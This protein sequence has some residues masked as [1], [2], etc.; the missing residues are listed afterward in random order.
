MLV[1]RISRRS[2]SLAP[3]NA[4]FPQVLRTWLAAQDPAGPRLH[5]EAVSAEMLKA[6][7]EGGPPRRAALTVLAA[8]PQVNRGT[9]RS[10]VTKTP[11]FFRNLI[12]AV[13]SF[14]AHPPTHPP[15]HPP[16]TTLQPLG[17]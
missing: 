7:E 2:L 10:V 11:W 12:N 8:P 16:P 4:I 6:L 5:R 9:G 14:V 15:T 13:H 3:R 17:Y 1:L